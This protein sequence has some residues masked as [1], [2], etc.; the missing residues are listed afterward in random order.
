M[1]ID[2]WQMTDGWV[3][4]AGWVGWGGWSKWARG[5]GWA[6]WVDGGNRRLARHSPRDEAKNAKACKIDN[7]RYQIIQCNTMQYPEVTKY[8]P[9]NAIKKQCNALQHYMIA[10]DAFQTKTEHF[11]T[12]KGTF[13]AI[14]VRKQPSKQ[15]KAH[16]RK[17]KAPRVTWG[18]GED[19]IPLSWVCL[20]PKIWFI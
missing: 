17:P 9:C 20:R 16:T 1:T 12:K 5:V 3:D 2:K 8:I 11:W 7:I 10:Y 13:W 15:L 19:M 4:W 6:G 18:Y 14:K